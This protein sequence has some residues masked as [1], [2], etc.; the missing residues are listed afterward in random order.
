[1]A[2]TDEQ[3][4]IIYSYG[5][6]KCIAV[7]GSG[8]STT[9]LAYAKYRQ[10]KKGLY[11][12]YNNSARAE[13][14]AKAKK[15]QLKN[16]K[17]H[18]AHS[19][20]YQSVG[21]QYR[22]IKKIPLDGIISFCDIKGSNTEKIYT[23]AQ[24]IHDG[25]NIRCNKI[26]NSLLISDFK[27][28]DQSIVKEYFPIAMAWIDEIWNE[29]DAGRLSVTHD[30]YLKK[31][32]TGIN[33]L[34]YDYVVFDEGQDA[35][36]VMLAGFNK[37]KGTKVIVGDPSQQI[38][39]WR[40]AINALDKVNFPVYNLTGAFRFGPDIALKAN[41]V[42][43]WKKTIGCYGNTVLCEGLRKS[44]ASSGP[45][46]YLCRSTVG[47]FK[48]MVDL[49]AQDSYTP[50]YIEGGLWG[51]DFLTNNRMLSDIYHIW[52]GKP[53]KVRGTML[54]GFKSIVQLQSFA[55]NTGNR[56]I[57]SLI[58]LVYKYKS[59]VFSL[60]D[61]IKLRLIDDKSE[62]GA[63]FSTVHKAKGQEYSRVILDDTFIL[64][65]D[66]IALSEAMKIDMERNKKL[67]PDLAA[68]VHRINEEINIRYVAIT[69]AMNSVVL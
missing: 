69:R 46:A 2:F 10:H 39:T 37:Q 48:K 49:V 47:L 21:K 44:P 51:N 20:A 4:E 33:D 11:L 57:G 3:Q 1:M 6:V 66:V 38:Y 25:I 68:Q 35:N 65:E 52:S 22:I 29:M 53:K 19:L 60:K 34:G 9:L 50:L 7:A 5:N 59:D 45:T 15:Y 30:F 14:R 43:Q 26:S 67:S 8:K 23:I 63:I 54:K 41:H 16:L 36:E 12:V 17:V 62:A 61:Q 56:E 32:I 27:N 24:I 58:D 42:L 55:K 13:A 31:F 28:Y 40:G 18:T 64:Y